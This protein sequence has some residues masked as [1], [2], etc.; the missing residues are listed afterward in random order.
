MA[1]GFVLISRGSVIGFSVSISCKQ[2]FKVVLNIV[3]EQCAAVCAVVWFKTKTNCW[4]QNYWEQGVRLPL[5]FY[6]S[7]AGYFSAIFENE[8]IN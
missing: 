5:L 3:V 8:S 2:T 7:V 4:K 1:N 6:A